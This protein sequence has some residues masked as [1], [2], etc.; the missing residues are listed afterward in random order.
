MTKNFSECVKDQFKRY[1]VSEAQSK[2]KSMSGYPTMKLQNT[3]DIK[4]V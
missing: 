4:K 2:N 3:K 1:S